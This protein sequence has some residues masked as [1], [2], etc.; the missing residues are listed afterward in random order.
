MEDE[1]LL[2]I[3]AEEEEEEEEEEEAAAIPIPIKLQLNAIGVIDWATFSM[4]AP[5]GTK[6]ATMPSLM[7][8]MRCC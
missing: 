2:L 5:L 4:S 1:V 7:R 8:M 3:G 6:K